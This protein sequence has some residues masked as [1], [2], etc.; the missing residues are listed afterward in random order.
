MRREPKS[1]S[2]RRPDGNR[3]WV[4]D[5]KGVLVDRDNARHT[6]RERLQEFGASETMAG[7]KVISR[8][9]APR[10]TDAAAWALFPYADYDVVIVDSLNSS[11]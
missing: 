10:L 6:V 11:A 5:L 3:G 7:L 4:N 8:E 1:F 9:K 2:F